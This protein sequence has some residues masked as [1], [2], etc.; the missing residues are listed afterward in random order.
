MPDECAKARLIQAELV[1][2]VAGRL[3][4]TRRWQGAMARAA[5]QLYGQKVRFDLRL[6]IAMALTEVFGAETPS[7]E[8]VELIEAM[9]PIELSELEP[10][11]ARVR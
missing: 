9:L 1:R 6:P 2:S 7:E 8:L 3:R 5:G 10:L 4:T 11:T